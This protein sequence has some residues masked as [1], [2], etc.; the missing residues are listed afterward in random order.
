MRLINIEPL[1]E[2]G[3]VLERHGVANCHLATMSLADVPAIDPKSLRPKGRW[4]F[5][6]ELVMWGHP[7]VCSACGMANCSMS[8]YCP[9]CGAKME[10]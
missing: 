7:Y 4:T 9:S 3:W 8:K 6:E 5:C 1:I 2:N 10:G